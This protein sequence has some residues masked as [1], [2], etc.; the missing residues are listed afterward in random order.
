M[1]GFLLALQQHPDLVEPVTAAAAAGLTGTA[2]RDGR[3]RCCECGEWESV[4]AGWPGVLDCYGYGICMR[5]VWHAKGQR[6]A[7]LAEDEWDWHP[8]ARERAQAEDHTLSVAPGDVCVSCFE[9]R[10]ARWARSGGVATAA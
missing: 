2:V 7:R 10:A 4:L 1:R 3:F 9:G 8:V 5:D 6:A